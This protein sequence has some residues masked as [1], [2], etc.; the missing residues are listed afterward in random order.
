[1]TYTLTI[2]GRLPGLNEYTSAQRT[3]RYL[4][5]KFKRDTQAL[6]GWAIKRQLPGLR[7]ERP[8]TITY[9]WFEPNRRRDKDNVAFAKKF[10]QDALVEIGVL[11]NDGWRNIVRTSDTVAV[12]ATNPR[13][14]VW[15][16]E[17]GEDVD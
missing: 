9:V 5:A 10:V 13:V 6:I 15:I 4:A 1:M 8:V 14:E 7:I 3:N 12:D 11:S 16:E 17:V 2:P